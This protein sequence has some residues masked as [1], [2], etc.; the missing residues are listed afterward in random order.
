V[1]GIDFSRFD[2]LS[3]DCYGTLVDWETGILEALRP[4]L[5]GRGASLGDETILELYAKLES[6]AERGSYISYREVL[7]RVVHG[8]G[9]ELGFHVPNADASFLA[10]SLFRWPAF[11]D[12][13]SALRRLKKEFA[14]AVI[15]NV[16]RDLFAST[17]QQ[18]GV[19]LDWVVTAEDA[20]T[21]KPSRNNFLYAQRA[22]GVSP[23]RWLHAAQSL[24]H[25]VAPAK[26]L[27]ISTI[28]VNRRRGRTGTGATPPADVRP[29]LE[30]TSLSD[31]ADAVHV[32]LR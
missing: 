21:Y 1:K 4:F 25:D 11:P 30:V 20:G 26:S 17:E 24:Y 2:V 19:E 28:W 14:L 31:L 9:R 18:L 6:G 32:C 16:D 5:A 8:F 15:S 12:T 23:Q 7:S 10:D 27:G 22:I 13:V 29:H 3:F